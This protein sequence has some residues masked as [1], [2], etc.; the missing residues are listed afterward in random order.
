VISSE[1]LLKNY[2]S[3]LSIELRNI[4]GYWTDHAT[5]ASEEGFY[6]R[7]DND[8]TVYKNAP[9]GAVLNAR[10]LWTFSAAFN[11]TKQERYLAIADKAYQYLKKYFVDKEFGGAFWTVDHDGKPLDTKKQIYALAFLQYACSEYY[12]CN[13]L[14]EAKELA[15]TLYDL[16]EKHSYDK[17]AGGYFE[18]FSYDWRKIDDVRLSA[19]DEN[20]NKTMNTHLHVLESYTNLYRIHPSDDL[21]K[22]IISLI[23]I[24]LDQIINP[25]TNHLDLFFNDQWVSKNNIISYGHDIEAAWLIQEAAEV[26]RDDQLI[27][28]SKAA[29]LKLAIAA[30]EGLDRDGGLWYEME[31]GHLVKQKHW[32]PQAEAIVGFFNAWQVSGDETF[33]RHSLNTWEFV[34]NKIIDKRNGEWLWGVDEAGRP[35][36]KEDKVGIWKCPYHNGRACLEII[37]RIQS[38]GS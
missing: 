26:I 10:I 13:Q 22:T 4:L 38:S 6:G 12:Q 37:K 32:W 1:S 23:N 29:A 36:A 18:A 31:N 30:T 9:K 34:K 3:E 14:T 20:E 8:G 17:I 11:Y 5:S 16:I 2:C 19:K 24:F 21:K 7:I 28:K 35:M 25:V 27:K 33:L 15:V